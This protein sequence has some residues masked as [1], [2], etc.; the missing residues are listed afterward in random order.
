V[1]SQPSA[2]G[3]PALNMNSTTTG[4]CTLNSSCTARR[5]G[6]TRMLYGRM[7]LSNAFGSELLPLQVPM[8]V[9]LWNGANA[10]FVRNVDDSATSVTVPVS[11]TLAGVPPAVGSVLAGNANI[12]FYPVIAAGR[13]QLAM[14][15]TTASLASPTLANGTD[16]LNFTAP[17][18]AHSGWV[19]IVLAAPA[20]LLGNWGNCSGQ[21][22]NAGL[23]DDLPCARATFGLFRSPL[24][25]RR[26]N[27]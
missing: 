14:A 7:K 4:D 17:G 5:I 21:G 26:E 25:Y 2:P 8:E 1:I 9:Q 18:I 15:N 19:D 3:A 16:Q 20:H 24:I 12:Y 13:N 11:I 6:T 27:Y 22:G 23:F 10:G